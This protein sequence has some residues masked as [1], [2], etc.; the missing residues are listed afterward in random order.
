MNQLNLVF[1]KLSKKLFLFLLLGCFF[2]TR[3]SFASSLSVALQKLDQDI[4]KQVKEKKVVGCAVAVLDHDQVVFLKTYGVQKSGEGR[5]VDLDT[6]FQLGSIS[7]PIT[8]TLVA[9]LQKQGLI[10]LDTPAQSHFFCLKPT[11]KIRHI[12]SHTT[13]YKRLGWNNKIENGTSKEKLL[14]E[15]EKAPQDEPG[16]A[17]DYHNFVYSLIE[18]MIEQSHRQSFKDILYQRLFTPLGMHRATVGFTDF[19]NQDNNKAWPHQVGK[20]NVINPSKSYS[21]FYHAAVPSAGGVNASITDMIQFLRLQLVGSQEFLSTYDLE[22]FHSPVAEAKDA[23]TW[24]KNVFKGDKKS[25][26]GFGWRI[27]ETNQRRI[28]FHGGFLKGFINFLGFLAD[29]KIGIIILHNAENGFAGR[30]GIQFL[31]ECL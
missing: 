27:I 28:V 18:G 24:F 8:S 31:H 12:L 3:A 9:I 19:N 26:Y 11:T 29:R 21:R 30:T 22:P 2:I 15:L 25:Y 10:N 6:V 1:V 17:F 4:Q 5:K 7:K 14:E 16:Q 20:N 23:L 13:G